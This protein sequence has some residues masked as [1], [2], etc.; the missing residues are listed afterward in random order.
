MVIAKALEFIASSIDDE[1][2]GK[3]VKKEQQ[4]VVRLNKVAQEG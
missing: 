4:H 1:H 3:E 2:E